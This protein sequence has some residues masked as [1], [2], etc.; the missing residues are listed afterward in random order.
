MEIDSWIK[1]QTKGKIHHIAKK[2]PKN[3]NPSHLMRSYVATN[4]KPI[5]LSIF[6]TEKMEEKVRRGLRTVCARII[7]C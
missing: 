5:T 7:P 4:L 6:N 2:Y 1:Q 3:A